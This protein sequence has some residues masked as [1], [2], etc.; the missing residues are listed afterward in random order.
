MLKIWSGCP[1]DRCTGY[2]PQIV[3]V[4]DTIDD[5]HQLSRIEFVNGKGEQE[6]CRAHVNGLKKYVPITREGL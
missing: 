5:T 4:I 1:A 3:R 6:I 2:P